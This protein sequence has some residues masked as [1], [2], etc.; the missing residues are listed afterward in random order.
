MRWDVIIPAWLDPIKADSDVRSVLGNSPA[1]WMVGERDYDVPSCEWQ[2]IADTEGENY[3][4]TL[5]QLDFF[6]HK[7][8]DVQTLERTL[9]R[10]CHHDTPITLDGHE[11]WSQLVGGGPL[12]GP[13]DGVLRRRLDFRL[14]YL[15]SR[16]A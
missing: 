1:L 7:L 4:V 11:L 13:D 10:L 16:Y 14:T 8:Q 9:R 12:Q 6:V 15:R 5:V 2:L 3:E